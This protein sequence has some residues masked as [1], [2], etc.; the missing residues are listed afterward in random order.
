[1]ILSYSFFDLVHDFMDKAN[2][3]P[4]K[5][6]MDEITKVRTRIEKGKAETQQGRIV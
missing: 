3:R 4:R 6:L 2:D 5:T 1:M